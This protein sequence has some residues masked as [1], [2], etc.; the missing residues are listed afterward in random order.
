MKDSAK[1]I[2]KGFLKITDAVTGEILLEHDN[3]IHFENMSLAIAQSLGHKA[4]GP[5][6]K[7]A[8]GNGGSTVSGIG[9]VTYLT[10]NT[11]GAS[12]S[13][14]NQTFEKI[15]DNLSISNLDPSRNKIEISHVTGNLFSDI[16]I[17]CLLDAGEPAGQNAL[18][19]TT[20][21]ESAYVFDE[22]GIV[23]Y[24]GQLLTHVIFSPIEKSLNRIISVTYTIRIQMV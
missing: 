6:Y 20:T 9:T 17:S 18:D 7:C 21:T 4:N 22:I 13:L 12:A 1:P 14:Y 19:N 24:S 23:A 16:I 3:A 10:P 8:F 11:V 2:V 5:I 15:V